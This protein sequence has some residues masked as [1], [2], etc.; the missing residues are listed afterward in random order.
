[1][2]KRQGEYRPDTRDGQ[3][4]LAHEVAHVVQDGPGGTLR[5][6]PSTPPDPV[7]D[8]SDDERQLEKMQLLPES[9][10]I[11]GAASVGGLKAWQARSPLSLI[12]I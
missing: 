8:A 5:R 7:Q 2:Y 4:L 9:N 10:F 6:K 12:H 1:M 11:N 3:R